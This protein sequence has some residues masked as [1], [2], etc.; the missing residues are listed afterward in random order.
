MKNF[1][2]MKTLQINNKHYQECD[3]VMLKSGKNNSK[4][5]LNLNAV[6]GKHLYFFEQ[7]ARFDETQHLYILSNDEIKEGVDYYYDSHNN[8]ILKSSSN[9][10]HK[11]YKYKKV[12]ATTDSSLKLNSVKIPVSS[13][14]T[15]EQISE[16]MPCLPQ[17][18]K[19]FIE[20]FIS[21]FNKG[22]L[23]SKVLVEVEKKFDYS[24]SYTVPF[25]HEIK[26]NQ[27]NEISILTNKQETLEEAAERYV[28]SY[29]WEEEPDPWF[30]FMEGAKWQAQQMYSR[31]EVVELFKLREKTIH[32]FE[33]EEDWIQQN[34]K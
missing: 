1:K 6:T 8:L 7:G 10:D 4:I 12:C 19:S 14:F 21:E 5:G 31:E 30:D 28:E 26:L 25:K 24:I 17:I 16:N 3:V 22:N 11:V 29:K 34:L 20:Y 13:D 32:L 15:L 23:I 2:E 18:P 9:S 33:T 27:N